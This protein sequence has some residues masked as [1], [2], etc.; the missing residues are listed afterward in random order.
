MR[1]VSLAC[2]GDVVNNLHHPFAIQLNIVRQQAIALCKKFS[3]FQPVFF[4]W[5]FLNLP[6]FA[7]PI[8]RAFDNNLMRFCCT[9]QDTRE[10]F[11]D[12]LRVCGLLIVQLFSSSGNVLLHIRIP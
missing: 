3:G 6:C 7:A 10:V 12:F 1:S 2:F 9:A 5:P 8:T 4:R 11:K